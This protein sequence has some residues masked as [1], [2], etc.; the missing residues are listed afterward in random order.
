MLHRF[1]TMLCAKEWELEAARLEPI[2]SKLQLTQEEVCFLQRYNARSTTGYSKNLHLKNL[3]LRVD[4]PRR[5][6]SQV[7]E[8]LI[9]P[10]WFAACFTEDCTNASMWGSYGA[11]HTGVA[12]K[13]RASCLPG[14]GPALVL[15]GAIGWSGGAKDQPSSP[16]F[17]KQSFP[18][19]R[20]TY[21]SEPPA[22]DF[23][24]FL[25]RLPSDAYLKT[26]L[27]D[28]LGRHSE[29]LKGVF[30]DVEQWRRQLW[31]LF[32]S[33]T[34][35]KLKDWE[36]EREYRIVDADSIGVRAQHRHL[37][38]PFEAL[39]GIVFGL[40]T[41]DEDKARIVEIVERK[42]RESRRTDFEIRP[43]ALFAYDAEDRD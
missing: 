1:L 4:F 10:P 43:G 36:F 2:L 32:S 42:C 15:E 23:F 26:W 31:D 29:R 6:I 3:Y 24:R 33:G 16:M 25:G 18:L 12:L 39:T 28:D 13:F 22:V 14:Q 8:S 21:G 37:R 34:T 5:Y 20:V 19:H 7:V 38:Y 9:H 41:S 27:S 11:S 35:S 40:R 17:G 30:Y